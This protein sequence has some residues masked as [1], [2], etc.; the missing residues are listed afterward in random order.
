MQEPI[1]IAGE[2][3]ERHGLVLI[4]HTNLGQPCRQVLVLDHRLAEPFR[5]EVPHQ[6]EQGLQGSAQ[7]G[8]SRRGL[9]LAGVIG[10]KVCSKDPVP[11]V[12]RMEALVSMG[13]LLWEASSE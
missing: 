12:M 2:G 1:A 8:F 11:L 5:Q 9:Y 3:A 4:Q 7:V 10:T 6:I 13:L